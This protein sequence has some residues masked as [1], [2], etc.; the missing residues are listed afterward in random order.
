MEYQ[1]LATGL[2]KFRQVDHD[3]GSWN[4]VIIPSRTNNH[5]KRKLSLGNHAHKVYMIVLVMYVETAKC[6]MDTPY[7]RWA[8]M[9]YYE[10]PFQWSN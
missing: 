6:E 4:T 3:G 7:V 9:L 5:P 1:I 2:G 8:F 10:Q